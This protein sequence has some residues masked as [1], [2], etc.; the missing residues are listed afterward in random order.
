MLFPLSTAFL[1]SGTDCLF[2]RWYHLGCL[3][4]SAIPHAAGCSGAILKLNRL[5]HKT[6]YK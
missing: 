4:P 1:L 6:Q 2:D 5:A 3:V